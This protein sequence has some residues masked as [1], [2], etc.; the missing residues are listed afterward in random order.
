[1]LSWLQVKLMVVEMEQMLVG[2]V[3]YVGQICA[4]MGK[5][6]LH[7]GGHLQ[8]SRKNPES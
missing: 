1:M 8:I 5:H 4:R 7:V 6:L 2:Y 3:G